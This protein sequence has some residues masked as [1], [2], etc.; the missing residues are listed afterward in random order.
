[1]I[2]IENL[3]GDPHR[4]QAG[5]PEFAGVKGLQGKESVA[6][7]TLTP[8][9]IEIVHKLVARSDLLLRN[10][11][12]A[13]S[14]RMGI[15][16]ESLAAC[17]PDLFYLYAGAYGADGPFAARPAYATTISVAVGENARQMGWARVF[18]VD[19]PV[20]KGPA[21]LTIPDV[22]A[23][24]TN[25][26]TT[27]AVS[28]G[29]AMLLGL[30]A[31]QR[32]GKGQFAQSSMLATNTHIVSDDFVRYDGKV[33]PPLPDRDAHGLGPLYRLYQAA[34]GWVFLAAPTQAEWE[35][36]RRAARRVAEADLADPRFAT[37]GDRARNA[38]ALAQ[39]LAALFLRAPA[40]A[41]ERE[42]LA[43]DVACVE[44]S[45]DPLAV[46]MIR[47]PALV[48]NGFTAEVDHPFFGRHVRHGPLVSMEAPASMRPGCLLGQHTR[49]VLAEIGYSPAEIENLKARG[50]IT[51]SEA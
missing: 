49:A 25:A 51:W 5:L 18:D 44:V 26:D 11:R 40:D 12:E 15:D 42:A 27:A 21:P 17:N 6:V 39:A 8:E 23:I 10:F 43:E 29:T 45:R 1:V 37:P 7:D 13:A 3:E 2:K 36:F 19:E 35:G 31:K 24:T 34:S 50:V 33:G 38:A 47:H 46:V 4:K 20:H 30:L 28:V 9:G 22:G 14:R 48:Q 41:W 16:Y 32:L